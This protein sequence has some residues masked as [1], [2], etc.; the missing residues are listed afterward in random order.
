MNAP[1][2]DQTLFDFSTAT[3][4]AWQ[5]VNDDVMGGISASRF[6]LTT[7]GTA[8]FRGDVS[9]QNSGGFASVRSSPASYDLAGCDALVLRARGD[10][11]RYKF[12]VRLDASFD[13]PIYQCAFAT[14]PGEWEEHRLPFKQF[15]PTYRGRVL[16]GEPPLDPAKVTLV[17]FLISDQQAG[18]F[19]LEIA[20]IKAD[21]AARSRP[22][23]S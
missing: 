1:A 21:R 8:I 13:G 23:R 7:N 16:T 4:A 20:W 6:Q 19:Q 10:G 9:L 2:P 15:V 12:T 5:V 14:K 18:A 17:G 11:K 3:N 22:Q